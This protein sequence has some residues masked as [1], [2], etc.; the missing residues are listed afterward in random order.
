MIFFHGTR[1]HNIK[2]IKEYGIKTR[3]SDQ[4]IY[5]I[6]GENVCCLSKEPVSGEGG[7]PAFFAGKTKAIQKNGYM[8]AVRF[9]RETLIKE[10]LIATVDNKVLDDYVLYHYFIR[11]EFRDKGYELFLKMKNHRETDRSFKKLD[12]FLMGKQENIEVNTRDRCK[13]FKE[14]AP[15]ENSYNLLGI[16]ISSALFQTFE[17]IGLWKNMYE[18]LALHFS[19]IEEDKYRNFQQNHLYLDNQKYWEKFY[20]H[21]PLQIE[22][23]RQQYMQNWFSSR[24]LK[25]RLGKD[26][27]DN[28]QIWTK[29]IEAKYILAIMQIS[30]PS[31]VV[32]EFRSCKTKLGFSRMI[33]KKVNKILEENRWV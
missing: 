27:T 18:F 4:W 25:D 1:E 12:T 22:D 29:D 6:T 10:K 15:E 19:K 7:N 20:T 24:W 21:F 3:T 32:S 5:E 31:G 30:T 2:N 26:I 28:C 13:Y 17:K 11:E 14:I 9:P 33:W 8:I 16:D 23:N